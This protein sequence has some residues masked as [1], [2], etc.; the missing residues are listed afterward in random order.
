MSYGS[1]AILFVRLRMGDLH[2][3]YVMHRGWRFL[4]E[5]S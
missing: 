1:R 3:D 4:K 2:G 5:N